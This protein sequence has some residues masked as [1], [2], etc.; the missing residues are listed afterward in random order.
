MWLVLSTCAR[1]QAPVGGKSTYSLE[2]SKMRKQTLPG[3]SIV[4]YTLRIGGSVARQ[5][6][7]IE[8]LCV[9]SQKTA[10]IAGRSSSVR[11]VSGVE[12]KIPALPRPENCCTTLTNARSRPPKRRGMQFVLRYYYQL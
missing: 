8:M 10:G 1:K 11:T 6:A 12:E 5:S 9:G 7:V 2:A 3:Q 4:H